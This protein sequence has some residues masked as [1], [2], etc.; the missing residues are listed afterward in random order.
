MTSTTSTPLR[1]NVPGLS[2]SNRNWPHI[3]R[4]GPIW[5]MAM[6][7]GY[8]VVYA[9]MY[10]LFPAFWETCEVYAMLALLPGGLVLPVYLVGKKYE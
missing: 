7:V 8:P 2:F 3:V 9:L 1:M 10:G 6:P 5:S 4:V